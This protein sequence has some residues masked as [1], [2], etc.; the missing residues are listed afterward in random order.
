MA[1][2][3]PRVAVTVFIDDDEGYL[4]WVARHADDG[5]VLNSHITD[6]GSLSHVLHRASCRT[7]TGTPARGSRWTH[8]YLKACG[9]DRAAVVRIGELLARKKPVYCRI[10]SP[11]T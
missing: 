1:R 2:Y 7:V 11:P 3:R 10:C 8:E 6:P 9:T 4:D 5:W